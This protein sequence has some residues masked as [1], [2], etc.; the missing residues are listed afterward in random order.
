MPYK[1][2]N[3]LS[4]ERAS[5]LG[6]LDVINSEL[7]KSLL[8]DFESPEVRY[9]SGQIT[10]YE[11]DD[12]P[13]PSKIVFAIDGSLQVINSDTKPNKELAF[14]KTALFRLDQTAIESIDKINPHPYQLRDVMSNSALYHSTVFPLQNVSLPD[15][16]IYHTVRHIVFDSLKDEKLNGSPFETLKWLSY[17]KWDGEIKRSPSFECPFCGNESLGLNYDLDKDHCTECG[18]EVLLTDMLGFH[19]EMTD[20][21]APSSVATAYMMIH[22]TLLLFTGIMHFWESKQYEVLRNCLFI[23]DGPLSLR[24][25]YVKLIDPIRIFFQYSKERGV[26]INVLG[27][28]KSG[29][30]FEHLKVIQSELKSHSYFIPNNQYIREDIQRRNA[31]EQYGYRTNYG[32]KVFVK[33]DDYHYLVLNIPTGQYVDSTTKDDFI[34]FDT[35]IGNI[36]YLISYKHEGALLPIELAHGIASLSTYPSARILKMFSD[37]DNI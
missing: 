2:G 15:Q 11:Y 26:G 36:K 22:E 16:N 10:N 6:H 28:E 25:Q 18:E 31:Q 33:T 23:K 17:Q 32:N 20:D 12:L 29:A 9:R 34:N 35:I 24:G 4:G 7:V 8:E 3:R 27:Q 13:E 5:K 19:L 21:A 30:F 37:I 14:I 1:E